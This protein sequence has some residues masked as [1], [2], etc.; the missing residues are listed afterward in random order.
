MNVF[1]FYSKALR[2]HSTYGSAW[3][4]PA[5][6][7]SVHRIMLPLCWHIIHK[8]TGFSIHR[9]HSA[10]SSLC[11]LLKTLNQG[12]CAFSFLLP[13]SY[14][15]GYTR[16]YIYV[17]RWIENECTSIVCVWRGCWTYPLCMCAWALCAGSGYHR[18]WVVNYGLSVNSLLNGNFCYISNILCVQTIH[19]VER[20]KG[21]ECRTPK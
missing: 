5:T 16:T 11:P 3:I 1:L 14:F 19:R 21:E 10:I 9:L 18:V 8:Y 6:L 2:A 17:H 12:A 20:E 13:G 7:Y 4:C 15:N